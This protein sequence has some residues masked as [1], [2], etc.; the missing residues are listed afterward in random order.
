M[1]RPASIQTARTTTS[2]TTTIRPLMKA[3]RMTAI[4]PPYRCASRSPGLGGSL[5][6]CRVA[7]RDWDEELAWVPDQIPLPD[8]GYMTSRIE[9]LRRLDVNQ[10]AFAQHHSCNR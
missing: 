8:A 9:C 2:N 10:V 5:N 4:A 7:A 6:A 3:P 1:C